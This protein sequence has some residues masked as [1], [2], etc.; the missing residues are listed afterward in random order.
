VPGVLGRELVAAVAADGPGRVA[1]QV[2][3]YVSWVPARTAAEAIPDGARVVTITSGTNGPLSITAVPEV[4]VTDPARVAQIAAAVNALRI[5]PV[6]TGGMWCDLAQE[7]PVMRL[8]FRA[9]AGSRPLAVVTAYQELCQLVLVVIDGKTMP[10]LDNA[11][12]LIQR[13]M[14][15]AGFRWPGFPAP[16]PTA[17]SP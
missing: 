9:S 11:Q 4:T 3:A 16:G 13:V 5:Y 8:T 7:G 2:D 17:T 12:T 10:S 6:P 14:A 15:I 1:I